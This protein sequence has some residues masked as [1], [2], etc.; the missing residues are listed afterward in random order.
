MTYHWRQ[1][2]GVTVLRAL[3]L[4]GMLFFFGHLGDSAPPRVSAAADQT[5]EVT[6][7][8]SAAMAFRSTALG[9]TYGKLGIVRPDAP[10]DSQT[11]TALSCERLHV[12]AGQGICLTAKRG[13][14]TSYGAIIFDAGFQ[15]RHTLRLHGVPSRAR[16]SP[17]G[18]FAAMTVFVSGHSYAAA[19]FSTLTS[20]IDLASGEAVVSDLEKFTV[21]R[22]EQ[23]F[24][25]VDSNFWGVTFTPNGTQF[26][27]TLGSG[28]HTYLVRG[29]LT[30]RQAWVLRDHVE[31]PSLSP[32]GTRIAFKKRSGS[33]LSPVRWQLYVLDLATLNEW[34]LAETR[35]VDDQVEWLDNHYVLYALPEAI[36]GTARTDVW[37]LP[38]D[39]SGTPRLLV[40]HA[41]S[42][43]MI[44]P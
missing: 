18:R 22:Q 4:A 20:I 21:W 33:L 31:C 14:F 39:G 36:S 3:S 38:A 17:D 11:M 7:V 29:D 9:Q 30:V 25:A 8:G 32:D 24:Q 27:A 42:P 6:P 12:T 37:V 13:M 28:G 5:S 40:P 26:Y 15:P 34:A 43:A 19:N 2:R 35:S 23:R 41:T 16:V 1:A 44:R 10:E